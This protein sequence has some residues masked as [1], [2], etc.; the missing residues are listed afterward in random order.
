MARE[1]AE[2]SP[3]VPL[4]TTWEEQMLFLQENGEP[5]DLSGY[6]IAHAQL[7]LEKLVVTDATN[8]VPTTQPILELTTEDAYPSPPAWPV[9]EAITLGGTAGTIDT[10]VNVADLRLASPT[11]AKVKPY[12][13]LV[14]VGEDDYRIPIVE[15]RPTLLPGVTIFPSV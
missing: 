6:T 12:W 9:A 7:R 13:Q 8:G 2:Y 4:N 10:K 5:V 1:F 11:N 14:L 3:E 15:G